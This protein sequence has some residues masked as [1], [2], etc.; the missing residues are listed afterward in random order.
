MGFELMTLTS[1]S[2][3]TIHP[4]TDYLKPH[5]GHTPLFVVPF[6]VVQLFLHF[7]MYDALF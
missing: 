7:R 2:A 3:L 1:R 5:G 4:I 6:F